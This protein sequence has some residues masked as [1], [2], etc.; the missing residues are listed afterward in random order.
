MAHTDSNQFWFTPDQRL[1]FQ[2]FRYEKRH[3]YPPRVQ[4]EY[5]VVACL[6]GQVTVTEDD[7][8]EKLQPGEVLIGNSRQ[9][10]GS[11]YGAGGPCEGLTLIVDR[12]SVQALV[13]ELGDQ[14]FREAVVP[15]FPGTHQLPCLTRIV[16]D[17]LAELQ[18]SDAGRTQVLQLLANELLIRSIRSWPRLCAE[19]LASTDRVLT[20]R[21]YVLALDYMQ[22]HGK[23]DFSMQALSSAVGLSVAEFTRLFRRATGT[24]P[25]ATYNRLLIDNAVIALQ[26]GVASIKEIAGELQ[27][28]SVSHFSSLFRKLTGHSPSEL[29]RT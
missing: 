5:V 4:D 16:E 29:R 18:G 2:H 19:Q 20:R 7:R 13:R 28:D 8:V 15:V 1:G 21:H 25:L 11:S 27:F 6:A 24:T 17:V 9:W 26:N 12:R 14:R 10:R 23:S 22:C 3:V